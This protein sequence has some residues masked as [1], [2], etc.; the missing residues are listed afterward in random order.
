MP[1]HVDARNAP[2][3]AVEHGIAPSDWALPAALSSNNPN[4]DPDVSSGDGSWCCCCCCCWSGN[5]TIQ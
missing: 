5:V 2:I 4:D 3:A 1:G